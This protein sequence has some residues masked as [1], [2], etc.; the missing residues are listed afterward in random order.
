[1]AVTVRNLRDDD[2]ELERADELLDAAYATGSRREE[3]ERYLAVQP[4]GWLVAEERGELLSIAGAI[5]YGSFSWLGFVGTDPRARGRG[6]ASRLSRELVVWARARGCATVALDASDEGRPVY[7]RLGFEAVGPI[8]DL[9]ANPRDLPLAG[10]RA[11]RATAADVAEILAA[12]PGVF[13]ADRTRLLQ[14]LVDEG[15]TCLAAR[16]EAGALAGWLFARRRGIGPGAAYDAAAVGPLV[17]AALDLDGSRR[18]LVPAGSAHLGA[19]LETGMTEV[20]RLTHM[21]FGDPV[22][23]GDRDRLFAQLSFAAG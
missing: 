5:A 2:E 11:A 20:R 8:V 4:D 3:L 18:L 22:L 21:R 6:L 7:E 13:G 16:D 17:R 19:L 15:A 9:G 1:M 10:T 14:T 12:D 23:P